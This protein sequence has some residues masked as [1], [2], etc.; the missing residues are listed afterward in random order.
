MREMTRYLGILGVCAVALVLAGCTSEMKGTP[1]P[2]QAAVHHI[3]EER[4]PLTARL[5]FGDMTT[6][7]YCSMFDPQA[8]ADAGFR[9]TTEP[10]S[11]YDDCYVE[12][13]LDGS[14]VDIELGFLAQNQRTNRIE[15]PTKKLPRGLVAKRDAYKA[16]GQCSYYLSFPDA[17]DVQIYSYYDDPSVAETAGYDSLCSLDA[18]LLDGVVTAVTQEKVTHLTFAPGSLGTINPCTLIP[19]SLVMQ[20]VG[21][22]LQREAN[23]SRHRCRWSNSGLGMRVALWF[24]SDK[25]PT[26]TPPVTT[27]TIAGRQSLVNPVSEHYCL[28]DTVVGPAPGAKNGEV[29]VAETYANLGNVGGKDACGIARA[30]A[31]QAWPRL[32]SS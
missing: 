32:P 2:N 18:D 20:Q 26:A 13:Q 4:T 25:T 15:D 12:G 21:L 3:Q 22:P 17:I 31:A 16:S 1:S 11:S 6:I 9:N 24:Y 8:A 14:K 10:D 23:P 19:D 5:A 27:E 30:L 29:S 7:D 28:V